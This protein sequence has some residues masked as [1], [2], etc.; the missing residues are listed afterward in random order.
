MWCTCDEEFSFI[1]VHFTFLHQIIWPNL[2]NNYF[3]MEKFINNALFL[4]HVNN[5][6]YRKLCNAT[7]PLIIINNSIVNR[8]SNVTSL[9]ISIIFSSKLWQLNLGILTSH[10]TNIS[11]QRQSLVLIVE[12]S[13]DNW[14][15]RND[16]DRLVDHTITRYIGT[17][18]L[19]L[20]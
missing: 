2:V 3:R 10:V 9:T 5:S 8:C 17:S 13:N 15:F 6:T 4:L 11:G 19:A 1:F 12:L 18:R 20:L 16:F 7:C 14:R